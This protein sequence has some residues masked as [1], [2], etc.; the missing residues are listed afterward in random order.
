MAK[1]KKWKTKETK[2]RY[3]FNVR[4]HKNR[5]TVKYFFWMKTFAAQKAKEAKTSGSWRKAHQI[6]PFDTGNMLKFCKKAKQQP[7][8]SNLNRVGIKSNGIHLTHF[9]IIYTFCCCAQQQ[10]W[11]G[12]WSGAVRCGANPNMC[13]M[14]RLRFGNK[15]H[16]FVYEFGIF[17]PFWIVV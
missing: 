14:L 3:L 6:Y 17:G 7:Q 9:E 10:F 13:S 16:V 2:P 15:K 5:L 8:K 12:F 4:P 1:C 11:N